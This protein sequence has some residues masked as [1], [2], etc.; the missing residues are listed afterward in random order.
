MGKGDKRRPSAVAVKRYEDSWDRIFE[1]GR[2][3]RSTEE[4]SV[5]DVE[6]GRGC[7]TPAVHE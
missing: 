1:Q 4:A 2:L 3:K 6:P 7:N 5:E